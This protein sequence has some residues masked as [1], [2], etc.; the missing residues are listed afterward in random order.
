MFEIKLIRIESIRVYHM[1][2]LFHKN[3]VSNVCMCAYECVSTE[4]Y[5][6]FF[7]S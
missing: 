7:L 1:V 4:S 3:F 6:D 2:K 5:C